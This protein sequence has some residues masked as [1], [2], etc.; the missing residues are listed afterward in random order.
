M[1]LNT[2]L[3]FQPGRQS[4]RF[5]APLEDARGNLVAYERIWILIKVR[6]FEEL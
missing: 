3:V 2:A 6:D 1:K 4:G 5:L